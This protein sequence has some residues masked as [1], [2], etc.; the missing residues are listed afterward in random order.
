MA[1]K[2]QIKSFG[3]N[4]ERDKLFFFFAKAPDGHT[5]LSRHR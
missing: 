4:F 5:R 3:A 1:I 2:C